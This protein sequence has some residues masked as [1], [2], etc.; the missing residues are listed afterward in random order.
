MNNVYI[1]R[2]HL[3][4]PDFISSDMRAASN[5][6]GDPPALPGR[7]QEFDI[8]G[9]RDFSLAVETPDPSRARW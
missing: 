4:R 3:S 1:C 7:Q 2:V 8:F 6:L 5:P 9:S